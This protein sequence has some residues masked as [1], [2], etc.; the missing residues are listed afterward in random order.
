MK[1]EFLQELRVGEA[2]LP[3][4]VIDAI[5][6]ENGKDIQTHRQAAQQWEE[7]YNRAVTDHAAQME[8]LQFD[9]YIQSAVTALGGRNLKAI[10]A[11]LDLEQLQ[12][13]QDPKA[14]VQEAVAKVKEENDYL[15]AGT[16]LPAPYAPGTGTQSTDQGKFP[17]TL[18]GALK[19]KF[20][21]N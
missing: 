18:A 5:M 3:K 14:A 4:E 6:A 8:K 19:E 10:A 20:H 1:R 7:K 9:G 15:F 11:L 12:K 2:A 17:N 21:K 16:V 13:S